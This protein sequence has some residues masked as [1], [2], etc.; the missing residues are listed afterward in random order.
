MHE[1]GGGVDAA[2]PG[3]R[4]ERVQLLR[5]EIDRGA[6]SEILDSGRG[7]RGKDSAGSAEVAEMIAAVQG[8]PA[9]LAVLRWGA[10]RGE[11]HQAGN[12]AGPGGILRIPQN[13]RV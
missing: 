6:P 7:A 11:I 8:G 1:W 4:E 12:R 2:T 5:E 13:K 10:R 3:G 9:A